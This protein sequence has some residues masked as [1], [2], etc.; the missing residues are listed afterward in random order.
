M[1]KKE[2][3]WR[4]ILSQAIENK[5][6]KF[7]Q[8]GLAIKFDFSLS[9]VFNALKI[10]RQVGAVDV[11][12]KYFTVTDAE[13]FSNVW[14][15]HRN[16]GKDI[17]YKTHVDLAP[18]K[19]EGEMPKSAVYGAFS[20][21]RLKFNDVP[22]DYDKVYIYSDDLEEIKKRFPAKEGLENLIILKSDKYLL[23]YGSIAPSVQVYADLWNLKEWYARDFLESLKKKIF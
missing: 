1:F 10:P 13:K 17:I 5:V 2:I 23:E 12:G 4:E 11:R 3:I 20:A 14:A 18:I 16:L 9:T 21:Y 6:N 22:A 15:T 7:T 19:I 8:K